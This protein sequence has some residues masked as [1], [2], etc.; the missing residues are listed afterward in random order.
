[1]W[2]WLRKLKCKLGLHDDKDFVIEKIVINPNISVD[3]LGELLYDLQQILE[4]AVEGS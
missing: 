4:A 1:M 3:A 2:N